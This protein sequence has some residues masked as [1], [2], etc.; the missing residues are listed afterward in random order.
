MRLAFSL[1]SSFLETIPVPSRS[2]ASRKRYH[3]PRFRVRRTRWTLSRTGFAQT[4][5]ELRASNTGDGRGEMSPNVKNSH[6]KEPRAEPSNSNGEAKIK[7]GSS[8]HNASTGGNA[9]AL[10]KA[11][12]LDKDACVASMIGP[13]SVPAG[14]AWSDTSSRREAVT[15]PLGLT[16][17]ECKRILH[18]VRKATREAAQ[19]A[20]IDTQK[21]LTSD[22]EHD[23]AVTMRTS[24]DAVPGLDGIYVLDRCTSAL[25][26]YLSLEDLL[27]SSDDETR[28]IDALVRECPIVLSV[29]EEFETAV[30]RLRTAG[31]LTAP[32]ID[33]SMRL[34]GLITAA[35]IIREMELEATDDILRF[36][37]VESPLQTNEFETYFQTSL[38]SFIVGRSS[39]LVALLLIQSLSSIILGRYSTL[40]ERNVILALFLTMTV[41]AGGNAGN[42]SSALVIRGLATGEISREN[43]RRV[44]LREAAVGVAIASI[45]AAVGFARVM[46]SGGGVMASISVSLS[47]WITVVLAIVMGTVAPL[48]LDRLGLD[49][50]NCASPALS[51]LTDI[52]GVLVLCAVASVILGGIH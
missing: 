52:G 50:C 22:G 39:W 51:T 30:R 9:D 47:L 24:L 34:V 29:H 40:I 28:S 48:I 44:V 10:L 49:P 31:A 7:A 5:V 43:A 36:G 18:E 17:A 14:G 12:V 8:I 6:F 42:Q 3:A 11:R 23:I 33:E 21:T 19:S 32:V 38:G 35:D 25:V 26:G 13:G 15:V 2:A 16:V 46:F 45:L 27:F 20:R 41:G 37:G 1:P 4:R